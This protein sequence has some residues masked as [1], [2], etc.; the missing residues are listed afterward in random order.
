MGALI[1]IFIILLLFIIGVLSYMYYMSTQTLTVCQNESLVCNSMLGVCADPS[2]NVDWMADKQN[3]SACQDNVLATNQALNTCKSDLAACIHAVP[4]APVIV[5]ATASQLS[6]AHTQYNV[7]DL[8]KLKAQLAQLH[9]KPF[10]VKNGKDRAIINGTLKDIKV[11]M[12]KPDDIKAYNKLIEEINYLQD[13]DIIKR[14]V[15]QQALPVAS[16]PATR[17]RILNCPGIF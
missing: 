13:H 11:L 9:K 7:V 8:N 16:H 15:A 4:V 2:K 6:Q 10:V 5:G 12:K 1:I 17:Y 3:L 14:P